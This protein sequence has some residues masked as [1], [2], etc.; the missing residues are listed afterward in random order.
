MSLCP[1]PP[2]YLYV[3]AQLLQPLLQCSLVPHV[4]ALPPQTRQQLVQLGKGGTQQQATTTTS[5]SSSR[6][7]SSSGKHGEGA[8]GRVQ[9]CRRNIND[10]MVWIAIESASL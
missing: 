1:P 6:S 3:P 8:P 9:V 2:P 5:T 10:S 7:T 4:T